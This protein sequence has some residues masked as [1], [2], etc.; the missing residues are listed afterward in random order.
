MTPEEL[1]ERLIKAEAK[2]DLILEP[3]KTKKIPLW[4]KLLSLDS[5]KNLMTIVGLPV[6][7]LAAYQAFDR[8]IL[9]AEEIRQLQQ[10]NITLER[11]D[12]L[13]EINTDIYRLQAEGRSDIAFAVI[14]AKRGQIQR[15]TD[16]IY[17]SWNKQKDMFLRHDLNALAEALLVQERTD[18]A[19]EVA[20]AVDLNGLDAIETIDQHILQARIQFA[21]GPA[22]N[23]EAARELLVEAFKLIDGVERESQKMDMREKILQ[24]RVINEAWRNTDCTKLEYL[25]QGLKEVNQMNQEASQ[26]NYKDKFMTQETLQLVDL[27]CSVDPTQ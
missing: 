15:L 8:Q 17:D 27:M 9:R 16:I 13:Q 4:R 5:I 1:Q 14:E 2:I 24:V 21:R 12:R 10:K 3:K 26:E 7:F 6:A 20:L 25:A 19:L 18:N 22:H 11:L 23:M